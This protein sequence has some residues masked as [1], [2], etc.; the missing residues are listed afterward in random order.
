MNVQMPYTTHFNGGITLVDIPVNFDDD[1]NLAAFCTSVLRLI[2]RN[3]PNSCASENTKKL[4]NLV[5][6]IAHKH[7]RFDK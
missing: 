7:D 6:K 2:L 3:E 1:T 4:V 5:K